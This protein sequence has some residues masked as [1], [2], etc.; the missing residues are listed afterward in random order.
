VSETRTAETDLSKSIVVT[1]DFITALV[2]LIQATRVTASEWQKLPE[3][4]A[5][6]GVGRIMRARIEAARQSADLVTGWVKRNALEAGVN[7]DDFDI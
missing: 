6:N 1:K 7:P 4:K 5:D 3:S 2:E